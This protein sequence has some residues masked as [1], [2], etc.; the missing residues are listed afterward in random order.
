MNRIILITLF[1]IAQVSIAQNFTPYKERAQRLVQ[2]VSFSDNDSVMYFSMP[3]REYL[4]SHNI[5][6]SGDTPR[7]ALYRANAEENTWTEPVLLSISGEYK[8]YEPTISPTGKLLFFNSDRPVNGKQVSK[9]NIWYVEKE[10]DKWSSP[11]FMVHLSEVK[12]EQ[13]YPTISNDGKL[14]YSREVVENGKSNY[15]LFETHFEGENTKKGKQI[16]FPNFHLNSSDPCL[17]PNGDYLIFTGFEIDQW[18]ETCDLYISYA[19]DEGWSTPSL[20][21]D[22]NSAGPDFSP[23][24]SSDEK[25]IYYRKNYNMIK[26]PLKRK[27]KH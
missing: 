1:F 9:N 24:I 13:S 3:H 19:L 16:L 17:S 21:D 5:K 26:A 4:A 20:L 6:I 8:D 22:L 14:I 7:L 23:T 11:K 15:Y 2:G 18:N 25:R 27:H 12:E 10:G